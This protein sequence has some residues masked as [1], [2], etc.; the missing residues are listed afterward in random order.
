[1]TK[2]KY[3]LDRGDLLALRSKSVRAIAKQFQ[4]P[5]WKLVFMLRRGRKMMASYL[6]ELE[7][8]SGITDVINTLHQQGHD[9]YI[10]SS[11]SSSNIDLFLKNYQMKSLFKKVIGGSRLFGKSKSLLSIVNRQ[12]K[13]P[14]PYFY[15]G[16]EVRDIE[17]AAEAG[18]KAVAVTWGFA[19]RDQLK[20]AKPYAL[21]AKPEQLL[22]VINKPMTSN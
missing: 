7:P 12:K 8:V 16:D 3:K 22:D 6:A 9:L 21:I 11:N 20:K 19:E 2:H 5:S 15:V 4:I 14:A 1:M 17:A 10:A 18:I 13:S